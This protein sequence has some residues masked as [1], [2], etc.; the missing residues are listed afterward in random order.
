MASGHEHEVVTRVLDVKAKAAA[1]QP[2]AQADDIRA[3][4]EALIA[5]LAVSGYVFSRSA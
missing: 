4:I 1:L 2:G 5:A 3:A